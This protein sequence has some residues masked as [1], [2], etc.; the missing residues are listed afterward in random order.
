MQ[1][2]TSWNS[3]GFRFHCCYLYLKRNPAI[4]RSVLSPPSPVMG[5]LNLVKIAK[6]DSGSQRVEV[7]ILEDGYLRCVLTLNDPHPRVY[8]LLK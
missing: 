1:L 8:S 3:L 5:I 4:Q 6:V 2:R 7:G